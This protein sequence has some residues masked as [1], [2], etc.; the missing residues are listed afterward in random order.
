MKLDPR[1]NDKT[2]E[3]RECFWERLSILKPYKEDWWE[4]YNNI[5]YTK[6]DLDNVS[7]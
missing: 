4:K 5:S 7:Y 6:I 1:Y 3:N 2:Q